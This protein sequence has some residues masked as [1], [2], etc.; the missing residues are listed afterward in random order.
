[1]TSW[2][3]GYITDISYTYGFYRE[4]TPALLSLVSLARG[5]RHPDVGAPL[6]YCELGCGQGFSAN[7]LA[8]ANPHVEFYATD[9]NPAHIIGA[10]ALAAES[11]TPNVHFFDQ[12]FA[13]FLDEPGLPAF[14]IIALHGIYSWISPENRRTIVE[15]IRRKLKAGGLVYVSYNSLPG[16]AAAAPLRHLMYLH[17]KA[18]GGPTALR[19]DS[20]LDFIS[21][22]QN[23]NAA[24][25]RANP[26]LKDRFDKLKTLNRNYVVHEYLNENWT[27]LY[28]LDVVAEMDAAKLTYV[29]SAAFLEQIDAVYLTAEQQQLVAEIADP[30]LRETVRDFMINQQFRRDV[31]VKGVVALPPPEAQA[32][33]GE[34]RFVLSVKRDDVPL[35]MRVA[36]GE[37][38]LQAEVYEPLLDALASG[39]RTV[40]Q[41]V[42]DPKIAALGWPRLQQALLVLV[43]AGHLQPALDEK[44]EDKRATRAKAFNTAVMKRAQYSAEL[45]FLASP[46]TGGGMGVDRFSQLFLL[47]QRQKQGDLVQFAWNVVNSQGQ[48]LIKDGKTLES[49]ED[50]IAELRARYETFEQ[51]KQPVLKQLA[52]A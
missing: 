21:K 38:D 3:S 40:K 2:T 14:D 41:L 25:F 5:Q 1:M 11:G 6:T 9:F 13:E 36:M 29:G 37:A 50:N 18:G 42:S 44:G 24:Y 45:L 27:L 39:P 16:W 30:V 8:A 28:H 10:R 12:S 17:G 34:L 43:G 4:L 7:L 33:W 51:K 19:L 49:P 20:A 47:G 22:M 31:F 23:A 52:I 35:K 26:A 15:F 32:K 46:V 48:R